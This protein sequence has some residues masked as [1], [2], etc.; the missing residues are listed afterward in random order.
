MSMPFANVF[1]QCILPFLRNC[2]L[3]MRGQTKHN[4]F[5]IKSKVLFKNVASDVCTFDLHIAF[6][7][8]KYLKAYFFTKVSKAEIA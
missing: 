5:Y 3:G 7:F 4:S 8:L 2:K 1:C 6:A